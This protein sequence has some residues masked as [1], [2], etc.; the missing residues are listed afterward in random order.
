MNKKL[1]FLI[2]LALLLMGAV[3]TYEPAANM[4]LNSLGF[5]NSADT[6]TATI[7]QPTLTADRTITISDENITLGGTTSGTNTGDFTGDTTEIVVTDN[8]TGLLTTSPVVNQNYDLTLP[9][10]TGTLTF[11]A[12]SGDQI[13]LG[14][15]IT[16]TQLTFPQEDDA[17]TPTLAFGDGDTGFYERVDD[18]L[19][20]SVAG[21]NTFL[22]FQTQFR[23]ENGLGPALQNRAATNAVPTLIPDISDDNTGIGQA[24]DDQLSLIVGASEAIRLDVTGNHIVNSLLDVATGDEVALSIN[25]TTNKATSG[26]DTGLVINQTD[27]LS[28][29]TSLLLDLQQGGVS[30]FSVEA[31]TGFVGVGTGT[32]VKDSRID[33]IGE[34]A[35]EGR[36]RIVRFSDSGAGVLRAFRAKGTIASPT[37]IQSGDTVGIVQ[38]GGH[39]GTNLVPSISINGIATENY[40]GSARGTKLDFRTTSD[41]S[42]TR[43]VRVT[44]DQDGLM[45]IGVTPTSILSMKMGT[46]TGVAEV[47]GKANVQTTDVGT[48]ADTA[49]KDLITYTLPA[50]SL[51]TDGK[52][53]RI[54][55]WGSFAENGNTKTIRLKFGS[56][57]IRAIG[58]AGLNGLDWRI[59]G[60]VIRTGAAT[61]ETMAT[62]FLD[63]NA[64]DTTISTS[65]EDLSG[66]VVIKITGQNGTA[67][68]NDI[69]AK[70]MLVEYLN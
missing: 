50:N 59:D 10:G 60:L 47:S 7:S 41:G 53:V 3:S 15:S 37:A 31:T 13:V 20:I 29:G 6:F 22:F 26:N 69:V 36:I 42:T 38:F 51:S 67:T 27:T 52:L 66:A 25:Y 44:I 19:R 9:C 39:D 56:A 58:P 1:L 35:A 4:V 49:E 54:T 30:Q 8:T 46:G 65:A 5:R 63:V 14:C 23:S 18:D 55:A 21:V 40:T 32:A 61:Q 17:V 70:G 2:P 57:I 45:G 33:V 43:S 62:E 64:Q 28:P 48:D 34:S 16:I 11:T 12:G 24:G 68:T